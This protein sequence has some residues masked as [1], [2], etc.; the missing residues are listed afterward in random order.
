MTDNHATLF[1]LVDGESTSN[2]FTA[3]IG[4]TK[5][6]DGL[7][8]TPRF[9]DVAADE[10][11]LWRVSIPVAEGN[12]ETPILLDNVTNTN[13]KTLGPATRLSKVSP[14]DLPDEMI[15]ITVQ[16]PPPEGK[17]AEASNL[18][19]P[20][21]AL[22]EGILALVGVVGVAVVDDATQG[23]AGLPLLDGHVF[24][25]HALEALSELVKVGRFAGA[26]VEGGVHGRTGGREGQG[27]EGDEGHGGNGLHGV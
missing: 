8:K 6:V 7:K 9:D 24:G 20:H 27:D 17:G 4:P 15:N 10:L 23:Q 1:C 13:I 26:L 3:E 19:T 22:V 18:N 5:T 2:A 14:E 25:A 21:L 11:I 16:R 12:D